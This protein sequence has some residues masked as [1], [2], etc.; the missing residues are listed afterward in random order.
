MKTPPDETQIVRYLD[1]MMD[2][3]ERADFEKALAADPALHA[4]VES[5]RSVTSLVKAHIPAER[6]VP[7]ADFFNS[8]IQAEISRDAR[9]RAAAGESPGGILGWLRMPWFVT[10]AAAALALAGF[11]WMQPDGGL[12][13]TTVMSTY[14]PNPAIHTHVFHSEEANATVLMLDGLAE[15]PAEKPIHGVAAHHSETDAS[16]AT[17]TLFSE[18]GDVLL[19][20]ALDGRNKP[21]VIVR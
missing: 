7:H 15:I 3:A 20:L 9:Q 11:L 17:T 19:V 2:A 4:E 16:V 18:R 14:A 5:L 1:G 12:E 21:S 8:Q 13:T 10:A 6:P